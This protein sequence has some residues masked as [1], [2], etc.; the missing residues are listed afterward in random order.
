MASYKGHIQGGI[1]DR[2][3]RRVTVQASGQ[4]TEFHLGHIKFRLPARYPEAVI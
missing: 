1:G 3:Q 4:E 2:Y